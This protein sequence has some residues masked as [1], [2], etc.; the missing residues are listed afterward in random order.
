MDE[1]LRHY[2]L[3][4]LGLQPNASQLEV[5]QAYRA[6]SKKYHPD[7]SRNSES[8]EYFLR[9]KEAYEFLERYGTASYAP[10]RPAEDPRAK[11]REEAKAR[12]K[13]RRYE[14]AM[15]RRKQIETI[16]GGLTYVI[17]IILAFNVFLSIDYLLPKRSYQPKSFII[18]QYQQTDVLKA[19]D[20]KLEFPEHTFDTSQGIRNLQILFTRILNK[21]VGLDVTYEDGSD[22]FT[23]KVGTYAF[24]GFLIPFT[25]ILALIYFKAGLSPE[26]RLTL[27]IFIMIPFI[28]QIIA[29]AKY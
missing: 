27:G 19:D 4:V 7:I 21:P 10:P 29:I 3:Q 11:W 26:N 22:V 6:L 20:L 12:V 16:V 17:F 1:I 2:H 25:F 15:A 13:T 8:S 9:V 24:F 5:K 28:M 14:E 23:P 18:L